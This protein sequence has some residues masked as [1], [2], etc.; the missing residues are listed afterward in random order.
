MK[1][2][3]AFLIKAHIHYVARLLDEAQAGGVLGDITRSVI[4]AALT[5]DSKLYGRKWSGPDELIN[6]GR[7]ALFVMKDLVPPGM[8]SAKDFKRL[9]KEAFFCLSAAWGSYAIR[10]QFST[11]LADAM[12]E[13]RMRHAMPDAFR[14]D[15]PT[16]H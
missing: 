5:V 14:R 11:Q 2:F 8:I 1:I 13:M 4:L 7:S 12:A 16:L 3:P 15:W 6:V 9:Y 10:K